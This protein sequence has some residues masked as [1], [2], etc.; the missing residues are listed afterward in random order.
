MGVQANPSRAQGDA[1]GQSEQESA[2]REGHPDPH[3]KG[4]EVPTGGIMPAVQP[5]PWLVCC[6][7]EEGTV[8]VDLGMLWI[9]KHAAKQSS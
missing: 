1:Q 5:T 3:H 8:T 9:V 6:L 7:L 2:M 4:E